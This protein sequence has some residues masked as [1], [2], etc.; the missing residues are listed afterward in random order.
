MIRTVLCDLLGIVHPIIQGGMAWVS[1][2]DL[3]VAV[4][5][6]GGLGVLGSG[7][8]PLDWV[9]PQGRYGY[10]RL[11]DH[12]GSS[13]IRRFIKRTNP[14]LVLSGHCHESVIFGD[15]RTSV[16]S[17]PCVNPGSEAHANV[18]SVVQ[19]DVFRPE[20]MKQFFIRAD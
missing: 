18:L 15:Y 14:Y 8:A 17:T 12:V 2:A 5:K 6:A 9:A 11:P 10:L 13:E 20:E 7:N 19:F 1:D 3:V 4:S 16:G